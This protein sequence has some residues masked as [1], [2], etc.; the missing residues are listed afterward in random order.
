[1]A[2]SKKMYIIQDNWTS[3]KYL[4]LKTTSVPL[5]TQNSSDE[6]I[7][8]SSSYLIRFIVSHLFN[9]FLLHIVW[10]LWSYFR[11]Q[12]QEYNWSFNKK[13]VQMYFPFD[14]ISCY[15]SNW[16]FNKKILESGIPSPLLRSSKLCLSSTCKDR[17]MPCFRP[18]CPVKG[19]LLNFIN[20]CPL[21]NQRCLKDNDEDWP[22]IACIP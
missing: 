17:A 10:V 20:E 21:L 12:F 14:S 4:N 1:M 5:Q 18:L 16:S 11:K 22:W 8:I 6:K 9:H 13:I 15:N 3:K 19:C 2:M 7:W